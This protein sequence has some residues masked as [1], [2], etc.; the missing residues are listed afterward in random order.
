MRFARS[1]CTKRTVPLSS[2]IQHIMMTVVAL[3]LKL[4]AR[5]TSVTREM[6]VRKEQ[7]DRKGIDE[8]AAQ[9][10]ADR[11]RRPARNRIAAELC[12]AFF[13]LFGAQTVR[14]DMQ[15]VTDRVGFQHGALADARMNRTVHRF[16]S[17][18]T[19]FAYHTIQ[20]APCLPLK[21]CFFLAYLD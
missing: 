2:S 8:R 14:W 4:E 17:E 18:K 1:S 6:T 21:S 9:T 5:T 3:R 11:V 15:M 20:L 19:R 7:N 12:A 16:T 13:R 10:K